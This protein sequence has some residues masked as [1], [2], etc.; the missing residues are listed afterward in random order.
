M[1]INQLLIR[2]VRWGEQ[3]FM[4]YICT[5]RKYDIYKNLINT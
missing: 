4:Q 3:T 1:W 5:F 2:S